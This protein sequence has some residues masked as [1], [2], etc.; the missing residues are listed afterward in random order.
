MDEPNLFPAKEV[1]S[2]AWNTHLHIFEPDKYPF[3]G[4]RHFTPSPATLEQL[5]SFERSLGIDH[6]C[7]AHGLSFGADCTSLLDYLNHFAGS[8]RGIC[9]LDIENVSDETLDIYHE[10]GVRSVRVDF[11][12]AKAMDSVDLQIDLIQRTAKRL[13][14]W[15]RHIWS[16]QVQQPHLEYWH[17]LGPVAQKLPVPLVVDHLALI[18]APSM[19][20]TDIKPLNF[21]AMD[22]MSSLLTALRHGNTWMKISAPYR[23]SDLF[24][25]FDD[26]E[27]LVRLLVF[28]NRNR[29][30][31]GS[32]WPHTQRHKDRI[33]RDVNEQENYL[34]VEDQTWLKRLSQWMSDEEWLSMWIKNPSTLYY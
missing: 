27:G 20:T 9:V 34:N 17:K 14:D 18:Q 16:V 11:F 2:D 32:D 5:E 29:V 28:T 24:H 13:K 7:I 15:G 21:A 30:I 12:K 1:P 22:G 3:S 25:T 8:A 33:G 6:I 26:L 4:G 10:A 23:C 31:W 19:Q